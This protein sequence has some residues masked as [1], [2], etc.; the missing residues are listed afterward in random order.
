MRTV[1]RT[2]SVLIV[3]DEGI[4]SLAPERIVQDFGR[5]VLGTARTT[6]EAVL[7]ARL[8]RPDLILSDVGLGG[9]TGLAAVRAIRAMAPV[10]VVFVTACPGEPA[11]EPAREAAVVMEKPTDAETVRAAILAQLQRLAC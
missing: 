2:A 10:P 1:M 11:L 4:L 8:G 6:A 9:D 7:L 3:E 5:D